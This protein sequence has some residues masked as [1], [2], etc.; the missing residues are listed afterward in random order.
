MPS[1]ARSVSKPLK[2]P[3]L[4]RSVP[5]PLKVP[6]L[7]RSVR[8]G[9]GAGAKEEEKKA[10]STQAV[11]IPPG[12]PSEARLVLT[13]GSMDGRA[14]KVEKNHVFSKYLKNYPIFFPSCF[15]SP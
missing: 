6:S 14:G 9:V 8:A 12:S 1:L 13:D 11:C 10:I 7:A 3:S 4:A 2:V 15:A 5:K